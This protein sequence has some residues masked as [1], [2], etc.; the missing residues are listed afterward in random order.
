MEKGLWGWPG[1]LSRA[2]TL[3]RGT[4]KEVIREAQCKLMYGSVQSGSS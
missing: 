4:N 1:Y 2:G 3:E